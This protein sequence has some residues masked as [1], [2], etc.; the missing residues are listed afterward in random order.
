M[1]RGKQFRT[2]RLIHP[3][4]YNSLSIVLFALFAICM[5]AQRFVGWRLQNETLAA[6][7][8]ALI[9]YCRLLA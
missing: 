7:G 8:Q 9:G 5:Y 6:H 4:K 1:D 3:I 2:R